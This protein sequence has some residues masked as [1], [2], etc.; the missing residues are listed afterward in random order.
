MGAEVQSITREILYGRGTEPSS[1]VDRDPS[2]NFDLELIRTP[3]G[4]SSNVALRGRAV[5]PNGRGVGGVPV[6][7]SLTYEPLAG[8]NMSLRQGGS[9]LLD[10]AWTAA[11]GTYQIPARQLFRRMTVPGREISLEGRFTFTISTRANPNPIEVER[12]YTVKPSE[13]DMLDIELPD[14][15]VDRPLGGQQLKG[16]LLDRE[17]SHPLASACVWPTSVR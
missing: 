17:E 16:K 2:A 13:W 4:M 7:V 3:Q 15:I 1:F 11:D 14:L 5:E 10:I 8:A 6:S 12:A 9:Q